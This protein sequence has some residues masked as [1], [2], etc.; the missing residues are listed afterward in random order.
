[1][2]TDENSPNKSNQEEKPSESGDSRGFK[3]PVLQRRVSVTRSGS[4]AFLP[5]P[6]LPPE[7]EELR[8][9]DIEPDADSAAD[10]ALAMAAAIG[11]KDNKNNSPAELHRRGSAMGG[12][13]SVLFDQPPPVA[14]KAVVEGREIQQGHE[15]YALTY[16][17]MLGIRV[18]VR[19]RETLTNPNHN[20]DYYDCLL[21]MI[22][23][24][25]SISL[26]LFS[27]DWK[28]RRGSGPVVFV[29]FSFCSPRRTRTLCSRLSGRH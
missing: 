2:K 15:Q 29:S 20:D 23:L 28:E 17:M 9:R 5:S 26:L 25:L 10:R 1:V 11:D 7:L 3:P 18:T 6:A 24:L 16:G 8:N 19:E 4:V 22:F 13:G 21:L 14:E 27:I 12:R